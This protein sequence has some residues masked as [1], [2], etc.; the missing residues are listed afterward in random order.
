MGSSEASLMCVA[1]ASLVPKHCTSQAVNTCSEM[2]L[3]CAALLCCVM[4]RHVAGLW[5]QSLSTKPQGAASYI[6]SHPYSHAYCALP[7]TLQGKSPH[8]QCMLEF[9]HYTHNMPAT[10]WCPHHHPTGEVAAHLPLGV[11]P[12]PVRAVLGG[13]PWDSRVEA[14]G[15][16]FERSDDNDVTYA[17]LQ[18]R[19]TLSY[20]C[21]GRHVFVTYFAG[22][23][24]ARVE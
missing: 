21:V 23:V 13:M 3:Q 14:L 17:D 16:V 5:A 8:L 9:T 7:C 11:W 20:L 12:D 18:V 6:T 1:P 15:R 19:H 10:L 24:P 22:C 2:P 4:L